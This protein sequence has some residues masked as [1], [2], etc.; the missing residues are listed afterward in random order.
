VLNPSTVA[1]T[2]FNACFASLSVAAKDKKIQSHWA[3]VLNTQALRAYTNDDVI[4]VAKL[5]DKAI[6]RALPQAPA[7]IILR[8]LAT[9]D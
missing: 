5:S 9:T 1:P 2:L 4:G 7:P 6:A 3:Q 8:L